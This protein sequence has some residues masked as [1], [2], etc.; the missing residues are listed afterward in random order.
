MGS[1]VGDCTE[2]CK[3][4]EEMWR[5]AAAADAARLDAET[6]R[7]VRIVRQEVSRVLAEVRSKVDQTGFKM[8]N[9]M[10]ARLNANL[11]AQV[12]AFR[13]ASQQQS[14]E[15]VH[16]SKGE[17]QEMAEYNRRLDYA[18]QHQSVEE[19]FKEA[20]KAADSEA[21][22]RVNDEHLDLA[23]NHVLSALHDSR[24]AWEAARNSTYETSARVLHSWKSTDSKLRENWK[25]ISGALGGIND[26]SE[27]V[28]R[29]SRGV[30]WDQ[31]D[32]NLAA[33]SAQHSLNNAYEVDKQVAEAE[34]RAKQVTEIAAT[35]RASI[36]AIEG[37]VETIEASAE[38]SEATHMTLQAGESL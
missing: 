19:S 30:H 9:D 25:V 22:K 8:R 35:N 26:A 11:K 38:K 13:V 34:R 29:A 10:D 31:Q 32:S 12:N 15:A 16:L 27:A 3:Q 28:K 21:H 37:H 14:E 18:V 24:Q 2:A 33:D 4:S 7:A 1:A 5:Q 17:F 6:D 36:E 23:A 20:K